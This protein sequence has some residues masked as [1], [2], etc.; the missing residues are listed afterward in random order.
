MEMRKS[1]FRRPLR[2]A[3][4]VALAAAMGSPVL[5]VPPLVQLPGT[6][7]CVSDT[8]TGGACV[9][10]SVLSGPVAVAVSPDGRMVYVASGASHAIVAFDRSA[11]T[12]A[13]T[14]KQGA[15]LCVSEDG[16]GG[17]CGDGVGLTFV[18]DLTLSPTAGTS[19]R[20]R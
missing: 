9:D 20:W 14:P 1:V 12:G 6:A 15:A 19:T 17:L 3:G 18:Q 13:L 7:A 8:G 10:G 4:Y 2:T 16:S 5:A 11:T